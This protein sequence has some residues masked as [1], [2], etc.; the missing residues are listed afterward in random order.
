[1][2]YIQE[3]GEKVCVTEGEKGRKRGYLDGRGRKKRK[4]VIGGDWQTG[5][6]SSA[7]EKKNDV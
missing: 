3:G 5:G 7:H 4:N 6:V 2:K 1:V